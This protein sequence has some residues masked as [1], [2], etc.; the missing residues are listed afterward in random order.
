MFAG[1]I[2]LVKQMLDAQKEEGKSMT[3][4]VGILSKM[5]KAGTDKMDMMQFLVR[6]IPKTAILLFHTAV[7]GNINVC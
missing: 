2:G 4:V 7:T 5:I 3:K 6:Y 1:N